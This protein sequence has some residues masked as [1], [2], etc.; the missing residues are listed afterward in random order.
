MRYPFMSS[1]LAGS[2]SFSFT[3][4]MVASNDSKKPALN[5]YLVTPP[6]YWIVSKRGKFMAARR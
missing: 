2:A 5:G 6:S 3:S 1:A 4:L